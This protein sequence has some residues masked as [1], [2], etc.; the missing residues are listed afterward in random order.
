MRREITT[1]EL[2]ALPEEDFQ[3]L[4][5]AVYSKLQRTSRRNPEYSHL[6]VKWARYVQIGSLRA[7]LQQEKGR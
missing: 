7:I 1:E 4:V 6:Q 3:E 2:L 5:E